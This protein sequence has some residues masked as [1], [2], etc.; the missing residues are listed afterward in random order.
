MKLVTG[1]EMLIGY[2]LSPLRILPAIRRNGRRPGSEGAQKHEDD[3][4]NATAGAQRHR[5][6]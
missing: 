1:P 4:P 3:G 6:C 5:W 2:D